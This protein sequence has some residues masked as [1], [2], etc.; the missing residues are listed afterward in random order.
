M[1]DDSD[2]ETPAPTMTRSREAVAAELE[3]SWGQYWYSGGE[4]FRRHMINAAFG[5]E[6]TPVDHATQMMGNMTAYRLYYEGT[7]WY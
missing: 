4:N 5:Y 6:D 1:I 3:Q 7:D 2:G